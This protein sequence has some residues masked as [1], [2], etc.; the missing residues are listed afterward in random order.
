MAGSRITHHAS[1][2]R[3]H[4]SRITHYVLSQNLFLAAA[5]L[6]A[7]VAAWP[8]LSE[9]GLLNTRGGGDS[10]FL[11]QRLHQLEAALRDGHFPVRWM[12]DA[13]YGYGYPFYNFYAPLSIYIAALFR[14]VG[15][16]YVRS[17]HLAQLSGFLVAAWGMFQLGRSWLGS[18]WAGL[19]AAVAYTVA[20]F[21]MVNVYVRGD[22][23]AEFWAMAFYPLVILAAGELA[24]WRVGESA[25]WRVAL[26]ALAYAG[27]ILSHNIS[28]L[29]FTPFLLLYI[30]LRWQHA[31]RS[32]TESMSP[33]EGASLDATGP[34]SEDALLHISGGI[35]CKRNRY[36]SPISNLQSPMSHRTIPIT[37]GLVLALSLSAW[38]FLPALAERSLAQLEPVTSGYFHFSNHFLGT[39]AHSLIQPTFFFDYGVDGRSAFRIGLAQAAAT[40]LGLVAIIWYK[41]SRRSESALSPSFRPWLPFILLTLLVSTFMLTPLSRPLWDHLPL[42]PFTQFPWRFLS[43]QAFASALLSAGLALLPKRRL[44]VSVVAGVLLVAALGRLRT[45]HLILADSDVTAEKLAQYE[46]FTGNIGSTVSF[47]YLPPGVQ[48]RPYTSAWLNSGERNR[49]Q[50]LAGEVTAASLINRQTTRQ[51]WQVVAATSGATLTFPTLHWPGWQARIDGLTVATRPTPGSGLIM[52]DLPPGE[53][54]V[55]LRLA[56]TPVRL[57]AELISLAAGLVVGWLLW[58]T[59]D[60]RPATGDRRP[61]TDDWRPT[62]GDRRPT[63]MVLLALVGTI[64]LLVV[65]VQRWPRPVLAMNDLTWDFAEMGYLHHSPAGIAFDNG[66]VLASYT[67]SQDSVQAGESLT[68]TLNWRTTPSTPSAATLSLATPAVNWPAF[69]PPAPVLASQTQPLTGQLTLYQF[70]IP[71]N[72]P[73]GL[74]APRLTLADG[75][76]LTP[77]GQGR[78]DLFLRPIRINGAQAE[79]VGGRSPL[80]VRAAGVRQRAPGVLDVQLAWLAQQP[81]SHNYNVSLRL[82]DRQGSVLAQVDRQPGYGFQPSSLWPADRWVDDWQA[83]SVPGELPPYTLVAHLYDTAS[84]GTAVLTRRLGDIVQQGDELVLQPIEP[85]FTLPEGLTEVTADFGDAIRLRGYEMEQSDDAIH[86]TL[87]WEALAAGGEDYTR[88]VH[89]VKANA[90]QPPV[91]QDDSMPRRNTYP[92]GQWT[93]GEIVADSLT[94]DLRDVAAGEYEIVVGFYRN[95]EGLPRLTAVDANG[96]LLPDRHVVLPLNVHVGS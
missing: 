94:L 72:A 3:H 5:L 92:T 75:R 19:L 11:L 61:A 10:P 26:F 68:V 58:P 32:Y 62:T 12:P 50:V 4:T 48:P 85:I 20:P 9:P 23:L 47:E 15:F 46:W 67:Y 35:P 77:S 2:I 71:T 93:A 30:L 13:N 24:S 8:V 56:H 25:S 21:H 54:T 70:T 64:V 83:L 69:S 57:A 39:T 51:T 42:L 87:F 88:F 95:V 31:S 89:L 33:G 28:A 81:L 73:A 60:R 65:G 59:R 17:I 44:V 37:L 49:L 63:T 86:L 55:A 6:I 29:I 80:D 82:A 40:I 66:A 16:S 7:G 78:G 79:A 38:F 22:S 41:R 74:Y 91:T 84:P 90:N 18:N 36:R 96:N 76:P 34:A 27:L 53:H 1:R 14:L 43:V 45:D 52:L